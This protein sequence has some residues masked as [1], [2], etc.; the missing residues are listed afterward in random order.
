MCT[1]FRLH[2]ADLPA[3]V[4]IGECWPRDGLQNEAKIVS[5]EDKVEI[6]TRMVE[7]GC[8]KFEATSFAHPKILPQFGDAEEVLR[9]IPRMPGLEY[10]GICTTV[11]AVE[12]AI[13]SKEEGFGVDEIAMVISTSEP[14]NKAN[15]GMTHDENK[16]VIEQ[17]VKMSLDSG[18]KVF[19][20][21]LTSFGCPIRG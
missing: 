18:H 8:R 20:W 13:R 19:G 10:R 2:K 21:A 7:A 5:T 15:V 11:K 17:M 3:K 4:V 12:R 6:I 1:D 9:R 16:K 14:H